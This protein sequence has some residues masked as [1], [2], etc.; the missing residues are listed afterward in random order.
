MMMRTKRLII[1]TGIA[2]RALLKNMVYFELCWQLV[3]IVLH[4]HDSIIGEKSGCE[5]KR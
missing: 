4:L 1:L 3:S 2:L 5:Q